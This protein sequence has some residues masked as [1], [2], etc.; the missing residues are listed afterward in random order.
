[1]TFQRLVGWLLGDCEAFA[2]AY[3]DDVFFFSNTWEDHLDHVRE[4]LAQIGEA[5]LHFNMQKCVMAWS[6]VQYLGHV[7]VGGEICPV[8]DKVEALQKVPHQKTK[9]QVQYLLGLVG[10][11][12]WFVPPLCYGCSTSN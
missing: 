11:Y 1:M 4:I 9:T 7:A 6:H 2:A 3:T 5:E 8:R 12:S 10:Y